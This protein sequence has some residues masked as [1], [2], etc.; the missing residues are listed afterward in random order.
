MSIPPYLLQLRPNY[1]GEMDLTLSFRGP[2]PVALPTNS[3]IRPVNTHVQSGIKA[4]A[5]HQDMYNHQLAC[6]RGAGVN[7]TTNHHTL[8]EYDMTHSVRSIHFFLASVVDVSSLR[9]PRRFTLLR[10]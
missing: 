6:L 8:G 5:S 1:R 2:F 9:D 4:Q 10:Q 3:D 7:P